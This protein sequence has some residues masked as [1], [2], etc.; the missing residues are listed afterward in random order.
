M[1]FRTKACLIATIR[2]RRARSC[3][4][5][6]VKATQVGARRGRRS[7]REQ[8]AGTSDGVPYAS[9]GELAGERNDMSDEDDAPTIDN[10]AAV[11]RVRGRGLLIIDTTEDPFD[12]V[13]L[14]QLLRSVTQPQSISA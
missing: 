7:Q 2:E 10:T 6:A 12:S 9:E 11:L 13:I 14:Q 5:V 8:M 3:A 1:I 4:A